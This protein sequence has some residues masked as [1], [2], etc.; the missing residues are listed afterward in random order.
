MIKY[1]T[2][3]AFMAPL[4]NYINIMY[5]ESEKNQYPAKLRRITKL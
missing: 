3:V 1:S 5:S 2:R 4:S